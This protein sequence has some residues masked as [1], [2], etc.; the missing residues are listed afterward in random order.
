MMIFVGKSTLYP[1]VDPWSISVTGF[2]FPDTYPKAARK[3][4]RHLRVVYKQH[5]RRTP[6]GFFPPNRGGR[7]WI[8]RMRGLGQEEE[9]LEDTVSHLSIYLNG[10]DH[11][12]Q[13]QATQLKHQLH[14]AEKAEQELELQRR[15]TM[16]AETQIAQTQAMLRAVMA[17]N[18]RLEALRSNN[19]LLPGEPEETHWDKST[20]TEDELLEQHLPPKKRRLHI[21]EESP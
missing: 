1:D 6:M 12:Y 2:T 15:R 11:L 3:V 17:I 18:D 5:L 19:G 16:D 8:D 14:R 9:D 21:E 10:L 7:S 20:Q 4:L 13:E